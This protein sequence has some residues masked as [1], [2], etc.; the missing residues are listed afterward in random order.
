ME[1]D[2][3]F[4]ERSSRPKVPNRVGY[5][6]TP[7]KKPTRKRSMLP[8]SQPPTFTPLKNRIE[9]RHLQDSDRHTWFE[10]IARLSKYLAPQSL[11]LDKLNRR[12]QEMAFLDVYPN[13]QYLLGFKNSDKPEDKKV[14]SSKRGVDQSD[15]ESSNSWLPR[16]SGLSKLF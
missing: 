6:I 11:D 10:D 13:A 9:D 2:D 8:E 12:L 3:G 5:L 4:K 14:R 7:T 16:F 1:E 15:A